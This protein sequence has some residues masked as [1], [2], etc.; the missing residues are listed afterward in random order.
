[1]SREQPAAC[2]LHA[3]ELALLA[4]HRHVPERGLTELIERAQRVGDPTR[5]AFVHFAECAACGPEALVGTGVLC[6]RAQRLVEPARGW[7]PR[8]AA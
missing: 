1:M 5:L 6:A 3:G 7:R 4:L 8:R 2:P